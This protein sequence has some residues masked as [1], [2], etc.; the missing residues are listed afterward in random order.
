M[1]DDDADSNGTKNLGCLNSFTGGR[2]LKENPV[3]CIYDTISD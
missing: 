2:C 1:D 3:D